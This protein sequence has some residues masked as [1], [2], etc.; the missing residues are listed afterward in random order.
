M[1]IPKSVLTNIQLTCSVSE[2]QIIN[3]TD[4]NKQPISV[5]QKQTTRK[6]QLSWNIE[7]NTCIETFSKEEYDRSIDHDQI[8]INRVK[9]ARN[10]L[11]D[12]DVINIPRTNSVLE[13]SFR[14]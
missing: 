3:S 1:S 12:D 7:Q 9:K 11:Y 6:K 10:V 5:Y 8:L 14:R 4:D 13:F 2:I